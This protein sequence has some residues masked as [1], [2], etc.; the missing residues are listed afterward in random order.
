[1]VESV[2]G[3]RSWYRDI[4]TRL[5]PDQNAGFVILMVVF[6]LLERYIRQKRGIPSGEGFGNSAKAELLHLIPE[7][8]DAQVAG[9]FWKIYRHGLLH[10]ATFFPK[11][12]HDVSLPVGRI[13]HGIPMVF[14]IEPDN[15]FTLH[16]VLFA[17]RVLEAIE[18]D[19]TT[20]TSQPSES[21]YRFPSVEL[22]IVPRDPDI[23]DPKPYPTAYLGTR[24]GP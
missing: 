10:Q 7:L 15:S 5:F 6:P 1:M 21:T 13:T 2:E 3:F 11:N 17:Q 23:P 22:R 19:F 24:G 20:F 16:P 9:Q 4:L 8:K 12:G 18:S 14:A